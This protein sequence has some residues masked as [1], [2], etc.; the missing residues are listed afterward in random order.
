MKKLIALTCL[1][2]FSINT[3]QSAT[4]TNAVPD[5]KIRQYGQIKFAVSKGESELE[6]AIIVTPAENKSQQVNLTNFFKG[7]MKEINENPWKGLSTTVYIYTFTEGKE[8]K[9]SMVDCGSVKINKEVDI[10]H[11]SSA[12]SAKV[13]Y[14]G[15]A[16][17]PETS[18]KCD[19]T[20]K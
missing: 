13:Y 6:G 4:F 14:V 18:F 5:S 17:L 16:R 10:S 2:Y 12:I 20:V 7:I 11:L 8:G 1:L 15:S 3:A 9:H 19:L